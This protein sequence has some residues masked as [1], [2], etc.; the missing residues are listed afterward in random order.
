MATFVQN[1]LSAIAGVCRA[2]RVAIV[3]VNFSYSFSKVDVSYLSK[4]NGKAKRRSEIERLFKVVC[5]W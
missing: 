4:F 3:Y 5:E 1:E 2:I